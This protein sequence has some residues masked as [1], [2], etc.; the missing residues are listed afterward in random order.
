MPNSASKTKMRANCT[1]LPQHAFL[2]SLDFRM[3]RSEHSILK[4]GLVI[5]GVRIK[6]TKT[7]T[8]VVRE[9]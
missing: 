2:D 8:T 9:V 6:S 1:P 3:E 4:T 5:G 7:L